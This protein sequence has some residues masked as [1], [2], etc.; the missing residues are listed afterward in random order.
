MRIIE[1][2][3]PG[4]LA[5]VCVAVALA[6]LATGCGGDTSESTTTAE[7]PADPKVEVTEA[8]IRKY[9]AGSPGR[10]ALEWW[11]AAQQ[12]DPD[13]AQPLYL[14]PPSYADLA[15][16]FNYVAGR[17][18]GAVQ[19]TSSEK[20]ED[21]S[22]VVVARWS[23]PSGGTRKVI[24]RLSS[25]GGAWKLTEIPFVNELVARLQAAEAGG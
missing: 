19:I 8:Q 14:E 6:A 20:E 4:R 7:Q 1:L 9:A 13:S 16:Q 5:L 17:L 12:N 24:L 18:D 22:T 3:A 10:T 21:G 11:R 2:R 25:D 15:G 23:P